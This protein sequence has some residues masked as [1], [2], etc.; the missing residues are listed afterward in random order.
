M[1]QIAADIADEVVAHILLGKCV[2]VVQRAARCCREPASHLF[3]PVEIVLVIALLPD[4]R[5][6]LA[7]LLRP[8]ER[9][10]RS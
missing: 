4:L 10:H 6:L 2:A 5:A 8:G 3:R 9:K 7:P 1:D